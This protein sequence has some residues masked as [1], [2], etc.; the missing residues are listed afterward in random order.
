[1]TNICF[2]GSA[3]YAAAQH[4]RISMVR[5]MSDKKF[6]L[7]AVNRAIAVAHRKCRI[8]AA[9]QWREITRILFNI[10]YQS[11]RR[12]MLNLI[13]KDIGFNCLEHENTTFLDIVAKRKDLECFKNIASNVTNIDF[14]GLALRAAVRHGNASMIECLVN[15]VISQ[16]DHT[17]ALT[18]AKK[19][20]SD[21]L[22]KEK[23][24]KAL[25]LRTDVTVLFTRPSDKGRWLDILKI[26]N[27]FTNVQIDIIE[28]TTVSPERAV[29]RIF[30]Q[31]S[32]GGAIIDLT[33][34]NPVIVPTVGLRPVKTE[35]G[36]PQDA[37]SSAAAQTG[38]V[39]NAASTG[40]D[41]AAIPK[42]GP[43]GSFFPSSGVPP[44]TS[45]PTSP[46]CREMSSALIDLS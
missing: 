38:H 14:V 31:A 26:L 11:I 16:E 23:V 15:K 5:C 6:S 30:E 41:P 44:L 37:C 29:G 20:V 39:G 4:G 7:S 17:E 3:L 35:K 13:S 25:S 21:A 10:R 18:M 2:L 1:M 22:A 24:S 34:E 32:K 46:D 42:A 33:V 28:C 8:I 43:F 19:K 40:N 9:D 36:L 12:D 45:T 27:S